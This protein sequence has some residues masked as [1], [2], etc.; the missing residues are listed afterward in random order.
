MHYSV[1]NVTGSNRKPTPM[2]NG[3]QTF[4]MGVAVGLLV[5][6]LDCGSKGPEFQS[7][8][9]Q[10]F[11]FLLGALSPMSRRF[12]FASFRGDVKPSVPGNLLKLA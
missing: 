11:I 3:I 7:H 6:A 2:C 4:Q 12:S 5:K 9:Q 8:L 10:R 1:A